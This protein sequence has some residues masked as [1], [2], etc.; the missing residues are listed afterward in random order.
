MN[1]SRPSDLPDFGKPPL[2]EVVLSLQFESLPGLTTAHVGLL[3]G[4]YRDRLAQI[5]ERPPLPPA[6][7]SFD[8]PSPP[9]VEVAFEDKP[10]APRVWFVNEEKTELLQV[11]Q[12][13][14]IHNWRKVGQGDAYPR[15]ER[16][17]DR[18]REEVSA[19][20]KFLKEER[21][22]ELAVNQCEV[23]Y[24]NH[25]ERAGEWEHHGE[26]EKLLKNWAPLP[27]AAFLPVPEDAALRWRYRIT[28]VN[29]PVGRL[30]VGVQPSWSVADGRPV[31]VMNLMAR[32]IPI[33]AGIEGAFKFFNLGREWVVRGFAD[34]TSDSMQRRWERVDVQSG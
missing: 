21:L 29:G 24:V 12:D 34:L 10:P 19:F 26:I 30:H 8:P 13:R 31:W 5:E 27:T 32:G 15:Y 1:S 23:T 3:W 33:G 14:F 4:R 18:F 22:G 7:E 6:S 25:I 28:S 20:E 16:I 9:R 2:A 17:R 11:Q